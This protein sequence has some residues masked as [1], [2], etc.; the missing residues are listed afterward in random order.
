MDSIISVKE[1]YRNLVFIEKYYN[2]NTKFFTYMY[3][4]TNKSNVII[5]NP[6]NDKFYTFEIYYTQ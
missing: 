5:K 3:M 2:A 4:H 1:E 6:L